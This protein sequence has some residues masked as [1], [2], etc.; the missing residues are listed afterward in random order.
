MEYIWLQR[1]RLEKSVKERMPFKVSP[2]K[3]KIDK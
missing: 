1:L 2:E 3:R